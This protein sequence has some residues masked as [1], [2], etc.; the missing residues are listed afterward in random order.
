MNAAS[1]RFRIRRDPVPPPQPA[2]PEHPGPQRHGSP[3]GRARQG[4][5]ADRDLKARYREGLSPRRATRKPPMPQLQVQINEDWGCLERSITAWR[6]T[7]SMLRHGGDADSANQGRAC[8]HSDHLAAGPQ[9]AARLKRARDRQAAKG[10][11]R[12]RDRQAHQINQGLRLA[13]IASLTQ[14]SMKFFGGGLIGAYLYSLVIKQVSH[15]LTKHCKRLVPLLAAPPALLL[16]QQQAKAILNVNIIDDGP[17]L[18]A[19]VQGSL[20]QLG[21]PQQTLACSNRSHLGGQ[22]STFGNFLCT[23]PIA[24]PRSTTSPA[25]QAS[26]ATTKFLPQI[27]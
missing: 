24:S 2:L 3:A 20:S 5:A 27:P 16:S 10:T 17:N 9:Q 14:R 7:L 1:A 15:Q 21:T 13:P 23:A 4:Q 26:A 11:G 12:Q 8:E 25:P 18:K 19:T 6:T 22:F